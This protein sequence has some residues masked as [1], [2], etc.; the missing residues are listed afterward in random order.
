MTRVARVRHGR[1]RSAKP[2]WVAYDVAAG[3][4]RQ[5]AGGD[6]DA[7]VSEDPRRQDRLAQRKR[8]GEATEQLEQIVRRAP[9]EA[10][11]AGCFGNEQKRQA[12]RLALAPE[13]V[14]PSAG[15]GGAHD[16]ASDAIG[17]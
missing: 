5:Y 6:G 10:Y 14:L 8:N 16:G 4:D 11:A 3:S 9:A 17:K 13:I 15:F 7:A 1:Q 12:K 2:A